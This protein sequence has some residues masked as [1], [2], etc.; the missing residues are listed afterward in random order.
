MLRNAELLASGGRGG[1]R[2]FSVSENR[3]LRRIFGYKRKEVTGD[4]DNS[5]SLLFA[6][7]WRVQIKLNEIRGTCGTHG[8]D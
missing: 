1:E 2:K 5:C 8:G 4:G 7:Y 3:M 6:K